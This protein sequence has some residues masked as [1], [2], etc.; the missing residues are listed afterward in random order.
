MKDNSEKLFLEYLDRLMAGEPVAPGGDVPE[1]VRSALD[2]ARLML[3]YRREPTPEFR[4]DLRNRLLQQLAQKQAAHQA[5]K[6][7]FWERFDSVLPPKPI[8]VAVVSSVAVVF[9]LFVGALIYAGRFGGAP[10]VTMTAPSAGEYSVQL[11]AN[12]VPEGAYF[13]ANTSLSDTGGKAA[14]YK[15]DNEHITASSVA[16]LGQRLGFSGKA[17]LSDDG[18]K[19][20]MTQG[21]GDNEKQ[22]TVWIASGAVEYGYISPDKLYPVFQVQLPSQSQAETIAYNFLQ[23]TDLLPSD[24][25][26]LAK[27]SQD[28]TVAGIGYSIISG[29]GTPPATTAAPSYPIPPSAEES[30]TS[31]P[32]SL[33]APSAPSEVQ[34]VP[35]ITPSV[36][37]PVPGTTRPAHGPS[38]WLVDFPYF[39]D[40]SEA[41]GPGSKI[42]V[43]VGAYGEVVKMVWSWRPA[44][45]RGTDNIISARQAFEDLTQ[46]KGSIE[47]PV[48]CKQVVV[49]SVH[50]KYWLG[51]PSEKQD[52]A[53]PVYEFTGNCLDKNGN[54]IESFTGWAPALATN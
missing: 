52:Y 5:E 18:T 28:T 15:V 47:V 19:Y 27:V 54:T 50:L 49:D 23:Q 8:L 46:G 43:S 53:V 51:P 32:T 21:M 1:E 20:I 9:L 37:A 45:Q 29:A 4:A 35:T 38:Y 14:V 7:G 3:A 41:T 44:S 10:S 48:D 6:P 24:Y 34:P 31:T 40:G 39:V 16:S 22:L 42:E 30:P 2:Q 33:P 13:T 12:I 11:P 36:P 17:R 26:N 25:Q